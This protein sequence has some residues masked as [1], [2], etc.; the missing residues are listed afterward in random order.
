MTQNPAFMTSQELTRAYEARALSPVEALEAVLARLDAENGRLNAFNVVDPETGR[1]MARDSEARWRAGAALG[2]LD[3]VPISL[4]DTNGVV[5]WPFRNGSHTTPE[6][7]CA[8]DHPAVA[9]L[10]EGGAVFFGKTTTPEFGWKGVTDSPLTGITRNPWNPDRTPGGSSGGAVVAVTCGIGPVALGG[11]GGGS[12]RMPGAFTGVYGIKPTTG[13]VPS[14]PGGPMGTMVGPGPMVRTVADCARFL[15]VVSAPDDRDP[16]AVPPAPT[17]FEACLSQGVA[18]LRIGF[19]VD[20]G[21]IRVV[22]PEV[23]E[24]VTA[25]VRVLEEAGATVETAVPGFEDPR[26]ALD[27]LWKTCHAWLLSGIPREKHALIDPGLV[28]CA[29]AGATM[30][31]V[32]H[33][34]AQAVRARMSQ[35]MQAFHRRF[36]LL[37]TPTMPIAAFGAGLLTPDRGR[38]PEWWDWS[39]F[40]WP[41]NMT[42][43]P[44]ATCPCGFSR[45]GL[46]IAMQI[47]GPLFREDLVL[48]ASAAFEARRP[49]KMARH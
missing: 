14:L 44:A 33:L 35:A 28:A 42:R 26:P 32:A 48:R 11:D 24:L 49:F 20:M 8:F 21:Y 37:V 27:V 19:S 38:F 15:D 43:Q 7:P 17:G 36:D 22:D 34:E 39:P 23:A 30:S 1:R 13:R 47:V 5:G 12:I 18:G 3:G 6:G 31:S 9:R 2:P 29:E 10:R 40:T 45:D 25:A 4:K 46:P 16:F 41:F